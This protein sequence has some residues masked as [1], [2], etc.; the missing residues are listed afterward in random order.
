MLKCAVEVLTIRAGMIARKIEETAV[1]KE[2]HGPSSSIWCTSSPASCS[3][4]CT[5]SSSCSCILRPFISDQG[6]F[7][8]MMPT[9]VLHLTAVSATVVIRA[10]S[11]SEPV[12]LHPRAFPNLSS[13]VLSIIREGLKSQVISLGDYNPQNEIIRTTSFPT[14][15]CSL[16]F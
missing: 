8:T 3:S 1:R 12:S 6:G 10:L 4:C 14:R 2:L 9:V 5:C 16:K 11:S 13:S 15:S 7:E